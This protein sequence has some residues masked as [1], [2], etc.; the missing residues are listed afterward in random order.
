MDGDRLTQEKVW[1][2]LL[3]N[4]SFITSRVRRV[5]GG[6]WYL[7][8]PDLFLE[9]AQET[10]ANWTKIEGPL[11]RRLGYYQKGFYF[12][13]CDWKRKKSN[14]AATF[15]MTEMEHE[16]EFVWG[17][18]EPAFNHAL[19]ATDAAT[20]L[21]E[22]LQ[23]AGA[24][25]K[26]RRVIPMRFLEGA[27]FKEIFTRTGVHRTSAHRMIVRFRTQ[28]SRRFSESELLSMIQLGCIQPC[29]ETPPVCGRRPRPAARAPRQAGAKPR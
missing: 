8:I 25:E 27:T 15:S 3:D 21:D 2:E 23:L 28:L 4:E 12:K 24:T 7:S 1:R 26:A 22:A 20:W 11:P 13:Y 18:L 10:A 5:A 19:T 17:V 9:F 29:E 6:Y 16:V 14:H